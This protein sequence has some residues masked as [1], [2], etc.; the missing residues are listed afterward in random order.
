M[1]TTRK[2]KLTL[3]EKLITKKNSQFYNES[4]CFNNRKCLKNEYK[5]FIIDNIIDNYLAEKNEQYYE[6]LKMK[7]K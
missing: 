3:E 6:K 4:K 7:N 2:F 5:N 1:K